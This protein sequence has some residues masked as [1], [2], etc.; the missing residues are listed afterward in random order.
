MIYESGHQK[1][2]SAQLAYVRSE[3]DESFCSSAS[4]EF[5][6]RIPCPTGYVFDPRTITLLTLKNV[7][8]HDDPW[9]G[10]DAPG[11]NRG[12][13]DPPPGWTYDGPVNRRAMFWVVSLPR[14]QELFLHVGTMAKRMRAGDW[15]MFDDRILHSVISNRKWYG[16]AYQLTPEELSART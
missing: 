6:M 4:S 9:V 11:W 2:T 7:E 3:A 10:A 16:C 8:P 13:E 14:F 5:D 15:V 12:R 1:P